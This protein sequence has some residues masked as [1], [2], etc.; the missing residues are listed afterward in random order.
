M[1]S[2]ARPATAPAI[3]WLRPRRLDLFAV[4][5]VALFSAAYVVA[6]A[7]DDFEVVLIGPLYDVQVVLLCGF[8]GVIAAGVWIL[9]RCW[10]DSGHRPVW[11]KILGALATAAVIIVWCF[12]G[13]FAF[14]LGAW[15][16]VS[17]YTRFEVP[18]ETTSYAVECQTGFGDAQLTIYRGGPWRYTMVRGPGASSDVPSDTCSSDVELT[19]AV[20]DDGPVLV[21]SSDG[22]PVR[23]PLPVD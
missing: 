7:P 12:V 21:Y 4:A 13:Y 16:T 10:A 3:L 5:A 22:R 15:S 19:V 9:G 11:A 17:T 18:G 14:F 1:T 20:E 23:V 6:N 2:R 8:L